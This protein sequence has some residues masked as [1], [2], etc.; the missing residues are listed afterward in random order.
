MTASRNHLRLPKLNMES[1]DGNPLTYRS[2]MD[3]FESSVDSDSQLSCIDKFLYLRGLLKGKALSTIAGL[4]LT[5]ENYNEAKELLRSRFGD[6]KILKSTFFGEILNLKP[7]NDANNVDKLRKLYDTIESSVRNLK[8]LGVTSEHFAAAVIPT[9]LSKIPDSIRLEVTKVT[10]GVDWDYD[11]VLDVINNELVA[12]EQCRFM[13]GAISHREEGTGDRRDRDSRRSVE[14]GPLSGA[15]LHGGASSNNKSKGNSKIPNCVY[16]GDT[17]KPWNCDRVPDIE[18]RRDVLKQERRCFNCMKKGCKVENC[19]SPHKCFHC[20]EKHHSSICPTKGSPDTADTDEE[21][22]SDGTSVLGGSGEVVLLKTAVA[23]VANSENGDVATN[24]RIILDDGSQKSYI[25]RSVSERLKLKPLESNDVVVK[26]ICGR[27]TVMKSETVELYIE[28][29]S[30]TWI[31]IRAGILDEI[32]E[33]I[34]TNH[35]HV[36]L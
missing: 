36:V 29:E 9:I 5:N 23:R 20:Q 28:T 12:R 17:H 14:R 1:Y 4:K 27:T 26:G 32:C 30:K 10:R 16:C 31:K 11:H 33:P 3:S 15:S 8:S 2:F 6:E 19:K 25:Q 34:K 24:A 22:K 18:N 13:S 35:L 7:V 21:V